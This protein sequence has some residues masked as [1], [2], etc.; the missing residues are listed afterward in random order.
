MLRHQMKWF[1][2]VILAL[3]WWSFLMGYTFISRGEGNIDIPTQ[4]GYR[5]SL[6][7]L[8]EYFD[9]NSQVPHNDNTIT[10]YLVETANHR[11]NSA[12]SIFQTRMLELYGSGKFDYVVKQHTRCDKTCTRPLLDNAP[13][14]VVAR[15]R[16]C[17]E[18]NS[19]VQLSP[20][21]DHGSWG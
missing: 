18:K 20:V 16:D 6:R 15:E 21:Q 19:Q 4:G 5:R 17:D 8:K 7:A 14:I 10:A 9:P 2:A 12:Y 1:L 3:T 13:C 11:P